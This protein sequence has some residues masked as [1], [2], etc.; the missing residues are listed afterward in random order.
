MSRLHHRYPSLTLYTFLVI[1]L[2]LAS[3]ASTPEDSDAWF[4]SQRPVIKA[5]AEA[6]WDALIKRDMEKA[7]SFLSP[8]VRTVV[9]A[10]QYRAKFGRVLDWRV[11]RATDIR[12]DSPTVAS[13]MVEL[14]YRIDLPGQRGEQ[15]ENK[16]MLTEKWLFKQGGWWYSER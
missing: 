14:T 1:S 13:V 3:C 16:T 9:S 10:Q 2:L 8:D 12:Y 4:D 6:R 11:A 5:R 15:I 7:Y